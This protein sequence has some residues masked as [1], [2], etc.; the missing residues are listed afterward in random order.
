M[1]DIKTEPFGSLLHAEDYVDSGTP[2]VTTEH[3]KNGALPLVKES[4]PQVSN[5]DAIRLNQ[6]AACVGDILFSRVG[7]VDINAE[8]T[9][10]QDGWLFSGR[11]LRA[12]PNTEIALSEYLH[13]ELE[14]NEV[15]KSIVSRAV[16]GTM[17]S[18]NTKILE[19]TEVVLPKNKGEQN[20]IDSTLKSLDSLIILHRRGSVWDQLPSLR[21]SVL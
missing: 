1:A 12:R 11:V 2:I 3:F 6:Y 16:G 21:S 5:T 19:E 13:Y 4:L 10:V 14:T 7:S 9:A 15:E 18:I 20:R 17:A 8:V